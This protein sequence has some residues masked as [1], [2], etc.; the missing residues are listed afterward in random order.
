M[1]ADENAHLLK[2]NTKT[3][4]DQ[5][6]QDLYNFNGNAFKLFVIY[7]S[8][9]RFAEYLTKIYTP[10][11]TSSETKKMG[12]KVYANLNFIRKGK[13]RNTNFKIR[14]SFHI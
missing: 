10:H 1:F 13:C 9:N 6:Q 7:A 2:K 11:E 5:N 14:N 3:V 4:N 12:Q 8:Y